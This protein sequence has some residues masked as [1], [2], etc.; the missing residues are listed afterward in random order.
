[1]TL[2]V[3]IEIVPHGEESQKYILSTVDVSNLGGALGFCRYSATLFTDGLTVLKEVEFN[4][5]RQEGHLVCA[6]K[7]LEVLT[8]DLQTE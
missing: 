2:R 5:S 4:H 8:K 6:T 1:V 3:T 7:A